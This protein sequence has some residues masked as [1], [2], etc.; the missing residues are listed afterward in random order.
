MT[1][2]KELPNSTNSPHTHT[3]LLRRTTAKKTTK[4]DMSIPNRHWSMRIRLSS[5]HKKRIGS[6]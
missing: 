2:T 1:R 5:G 4:P 6:P 3:A